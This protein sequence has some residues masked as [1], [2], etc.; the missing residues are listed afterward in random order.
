MTSF[1]R[2]HSSKQKIVLSLI[3]KRFS[4]FFCSLP[5]NK[6]VSLFNVRL[7]FTHLHKNIYDGHV[8]VALDDK[9]ESDS[10]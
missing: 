7:S 2:Y 6:Y 5:F 10:D 3:F 1:D 9:R 8:I 4:M